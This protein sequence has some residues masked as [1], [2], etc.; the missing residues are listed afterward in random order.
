[1]FKILL[2]VISRTVAPVGTARTLAL[3]HLRSCKD[4]P[5]VLQTSG[6]LLIKQNNRC[7]T[8]HVQ[9]L[10]T[11]GSLCTRFVIG[12]TAIFPMLVAVAACRVT[13]SKED[14]AAAEAKSG[15]HQRLPLAP[16]RDLTE[17]ELEDYSLN[18]EANEIA[19]V[20][21][22]LV[23]KLLG[24]IAKHVEGC[25]GV[26]QL[27]CFFCLVGLRSMIGLWQ[28]NS[29]SSSLHSVLQPAHGHSYISVKL[30]LAP[31]RGISMSSA[32]PTPDDPVLV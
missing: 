16:T 9:T 10:R 4:R 1:M 12:I 15:Q 2:T 14:V 26:L 23:M 7:H 3:S 28:H 21:F 22:G 17:D 19:G 6:P 32:S 11:L 5:V 27:N 29:C 20:M 13:D 30:S 25:R 8:V 31:T 18:M 24:Y